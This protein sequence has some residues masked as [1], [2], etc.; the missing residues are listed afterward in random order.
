MNTYRRVRKNQENDPAISRFSWIKN[1]IYF[2]IKLLC[3]VWKTV[4]IFWYWFERLF[5]IVFLLLMTV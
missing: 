5:L 1:C 3:F 2:S 4:K